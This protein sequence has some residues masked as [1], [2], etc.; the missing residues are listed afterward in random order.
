MR[1]NDYERSGRRRRGR[2]KGKQQQAELSCLLPSCPAAAFLLPCLAQLIAWCTTT[3]A[4]RGQ[5]QAPLGVEGRKRWVG[6]VELPS[7][8]PSPLGLPCC[9]RWATFFVTPSCSLWRLDLSWLRRS[10]C[11]ICFRHSLPDTRSLM[12]GG[13]SW[14]G[15]S[16]ACVDHGQPFARA[17]RHLPWPEEGVR[18]KENRPQELGGR[19]PGRPLRGR[20]RFEVH[21]SSCH[22]RR[23]LRSFTGDKVVSTEIQN[24]KSFHSNPGWACTSSGA[25]I[26]TTRLTNIPATSDR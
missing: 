21:Q 4:V 13:G 20:G 14:W 3:E 16:G 15:W 5:H 2:A 9:R 7:F 22:Q 23:S 11:K 6:L 17:C 12:P 18:G 8:L 24:H 19:D 26:N 1:S 25:G 10:I